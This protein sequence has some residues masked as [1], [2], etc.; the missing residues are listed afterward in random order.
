[1]GRVMAAGQFVDAYRGGAKKHS[2]RVFRCQT[3]YLSAGSSSFA[4]EVV[5]AETPHAIR[6]SE[7]GLIYQDSLFE[8]ASRSL[9]GALF[10]RER[11][12]DPKLLT[13]GRLGRGGRE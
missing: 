11:S 4:A 8:T 3:R 6:A 10:L 12:F 2:D 9:R 13:K 1:R 7:L 5:L